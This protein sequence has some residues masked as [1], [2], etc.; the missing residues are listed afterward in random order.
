MTRQKGS[1]MRTL[2]QAQA[3]IN[4]TQAARRGGV[5]YARIEEP[6]RVEFQGAIYG[7]VAE[8]QALLKPA[9]TLIVM[10][11]TPARPGEPDRQAGIFK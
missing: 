6:A 1:A 7:T 11:W 5:Y 8:V 10:D 2:H 3:A 4:K 9:D